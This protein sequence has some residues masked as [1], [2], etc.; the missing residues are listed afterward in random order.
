MRLNPQLTAGLLGAIV[1]S[2]VTILAQ[3]LASRYRKGTAARGLAIALWE[4]LSAVQFAMAS[5]VPDFAGFSSQVFDSL[6]GE[7]AVTLPE[8]LFRSV[9]RYH[10]RMKYLEQL[11]STGGMGL[12]PLPWPTL[13][14]D[15][16]AQHECLLPR[17][18]TFGKRNAFGLMIR[19]REARVRPP[20]G[21]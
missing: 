2:G 19:R 18:K 15:A 10:W 20:E 8:T 9:V 4:E 14:Q 16:H 5:P 17:L 3:V 6:F 13:C 1:G 11:R 21:G 7:L 12:T